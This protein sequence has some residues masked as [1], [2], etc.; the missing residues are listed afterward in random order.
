MSLGLLRNILEKLNFP[1]YQRRRSG[2][3][4]EG[5]RRAGEPEPRSVDSVSID[6]SGEGE[7]IGTQRN[8]PSTRLPIAIWLMIVF[9][10]LAATVGLVVLWRRHA[11]PPALDTGDR[12]EQ[13]TQDDLLA[14]VEVFELAQQ[15]AAA[16]DY[17]GAVRYLLLATLLALEEQ[18]VLRFDHALTNRELLRNSR[19]NPTLREILTRITR[20]FDRAW[21]GLEA[22]SQADYESLVTQVENLMRL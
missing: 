14:P 16:D 10:L 22:V 7:R 11:I 13:A 15:R 3:G 9:L 17:R 21:Y 12:K 8:R 2:G 18:E 20:T 1:P 6:R 5:Q 19:V 4:S